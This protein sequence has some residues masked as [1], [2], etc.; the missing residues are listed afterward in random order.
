M[1]GIVYSCKNYV[2]VLTPVS[3]KVTLFGKKVFTEVIKLKWGHRV[4][5]I[6]VWLAPT[7]KGEIWTKGHTQR[8]D[9]ES[10]A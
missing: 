1:D 6:P 7:E 10:H 2:Q 5:P 4:Y 9:L 8:E 3:V